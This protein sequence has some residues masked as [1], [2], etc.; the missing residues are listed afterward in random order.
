MAMHMVRVGFKGGKPS[1]FMFVDDETHKKG[2]I[3]VE[4]L[5]EFVGRFKPRNIEIENGKLATNGKLTRYYFG[6]IKGEKRAPI[7]IMRKFVDKGKLIGFEV[8]KEPNSAIIKV[9]PVNLLKALQNKSYVLANGRVVKQDGKIF[10][11]AIKGSFDTYDYNKVAT[12]DDKRRL[13]RKVEEVS[14]DGISFV[15]LLK[16]QPEYERWLD[17][18][19]VRNVSGTFLEYWGEEN[20]PGTELSVREVY[21]ERGSE[22][23]KGG[24]DKPYKYFEGIRYAVEGNFSSFVY[25]Y[26]GREYVSVVTHRTEDGYYFG[27]VNAEGKMLTPGISRVDGDGIGD[28]KPLFEPTNFDRN[29]IKVYREVDG[30]ELCGFISLRT[31]KMTKVAYRYSYS[32]KDL[33]TPMWFNEFTQRPEDIREVLSKSKERLKDLQRFIPRHCYNEKPVKEM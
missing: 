4:K 12:V 21:R 1:A 11:A 27:L 29:I 33:G 14:N 13:K 19:W 18:D 10:I 20:R 28:Y 2:V 24:E 3:P 8:F 16:K 9:S 30:K 31:G 7:V 15:D 32:D 6:S 5:K 23:L 22:I 17:R 25:D 26:K